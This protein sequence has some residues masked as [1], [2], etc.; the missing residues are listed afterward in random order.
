MRSAIRTR[1]RAPND[2]ATA[3]AC[4]RRAIRAHRCLARLSPSHF[5]SAVV[6]RE[7]REREARRR[8]DEACNQA[9][10]KVYGTEPKPVPEPDPPPLPPPRTR[11]AVERELASCRLWFDIGSDAM[12]RFKARRRYD[13]VSLSQLLSMIDLG[14]DLGRLATGIDSAQPQTEPSFHATALADLKRIYGD[15]PDPPPSALV[16][17]T[18]SP[19]SPF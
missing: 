6:E 11:R 18:S 16:V 10:A 5:N 8:W 17:G 19:A 15:Q 12:R 7:R 14:H 1:W 9:I 2:L 13:R 4:F 3:L